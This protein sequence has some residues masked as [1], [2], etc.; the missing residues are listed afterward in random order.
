MPEMEMVIVECNVSSV[1]NAVWTFSV[2]CVSYG[3]LCFS[4]ENVFGAVVPRREE[5]EDM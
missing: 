4:L 1:M 3:V 2:P 5:P